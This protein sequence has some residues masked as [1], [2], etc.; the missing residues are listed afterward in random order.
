LQAE[1]KQL[2]KKYQDRDI[3]QTS[4]SSPRWLRASRTCLGEDDRQILENISRELSVKLSVAEAELERAAYQ[5]D[6][7]PDSYPTERRWSY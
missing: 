1:K 3:N 4:R 2:N 7:E 5:K 6:F